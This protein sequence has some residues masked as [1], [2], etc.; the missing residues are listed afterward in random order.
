[1][2]FKLVNEYTKDL[3][4]LYVEDNESLRISTEKVFSNFFRHVDIAIDGDDGLETYFDYQKEHGYY[5]D[6]VISDINMPLMDGI[7]MCKEILAHNSTQSIIFITA[8]N[9]PSY[10][11]EAIKMGASGFL[12]KPMVL[13]E[14]AN[15]LYKVCQAISDRKMVQQYYDQIE[16]MAMQMHEQ[17]SELQKKNEELEKSLRVLD[18]M[19]YKEQQIPVEQT[20]N[21]Y[22]ED[23]IKEQVA[24]LVNEDLPEL[25]D[26]QSDIDTLLIAIISSNIDNE[27]VLK[28]LP[29]IAENFSRFSNILQYYSFY[30]NLG[31]HMQKFAEFIQTTSLPEEESLKTNIFLLFESFIF[32]LEKWQNDLLS[33]GED[34]LNF[35]D[36]SLISDMHMITNLWA[37]VEEPVEEVEL[38]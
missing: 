23:R 18:T 14:F 30:H 7:E 38:F 1:M 31:T 28:N 15:M 5:Y 10:L 9:E 4:V 12:I 21:S 17:N 3:T 33:Y 24:T 35:L 11:L 25:K 6:L 19:V 26:L 34:K 13:D 2:D 22:D 37:Q 32:V 36:A 16:E 20:S 27:I 29:M 8:H